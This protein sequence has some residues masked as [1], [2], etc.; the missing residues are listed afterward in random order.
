MTGF[1]NNRFLAHML[2]FFTLAGAPTMATGSPGAAPAPIPSPP[3]AEMWIQK[4]SALE[5][6]VHEQAHTIEA[7]QRR[8]AVVEARLDDAAA[9]GNSSS[10][11]PRGG[12]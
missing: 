10:S 1:N 11:A 9:P 6:T 3:W 12:N 2:T 7:Q 4:M 5:R 8:L